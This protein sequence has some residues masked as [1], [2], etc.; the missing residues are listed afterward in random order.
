[1]E[2]E[3][4]ED[5]ATARFLNDNFVS[6]KVD[7]EERP[8]IDEVYMKA[9]TSFTGQGGW[10]L[11]VFLTPDLKPFYG[12][13]YFPP[14]PRYGMPS[15]RQLLEF[16][17]NLW[18]EKRNEVEHDAEEINKLVR[19]SYKVE[20]RGSLNPGLLDGGY[21]T[22]VSRFDAEYG[23]YGTAPKFPMP[24]YLSFLM[25]YFKR[26]GKELAIRSAT[27]TLDSMRAGGI[28]DHLAG[29]F[30][31]YSTD[32]HWLVPHFEKM[33]YD[34]ALLA[35]VFCELYQ[36]TRE[37]VFSETARTTLE[38][39]LTEMVGP[40]GGF[41]SA[42][43]ADTPDGEG[44]YYTWTKD[45][46]LSLLGAREGELFCYV[47]GVSEDGNF[48]GGRSILHLANSIEA[49]AARFGRGREDVSISLARDRARLLEERS[50]RRRPA[51]DDKILTSWNG[52][53][54]SAFAY[55]YQ[56]LQEE[57]FLTAAEKAADF[58]LTRLM[59]K[60]GR[61][62][63]RYRE[64][65]VAVPA[66]LEDYS[67]LVLGL[68][69]LY[70]ADLRSRWLEH[71]VK[72]AERMI[73]LFWDRE[74]GGGF[75]LSLPSGDLQVRVKEGYDGPIPSG[76]SAAALAL[77]K[78]AELTGK[79]GFRTTAEK[80]LQIFSDSMDAEAS[81]HTAMLSAL[82]FLYGPPKE[83]VVA[84]KKKIDAL[85]MLK[86]IQTRFMPDKVLCLVSEDDP[87]S[88]YSSPLTEGKSALEEGRPT[89]FICE[90]FSCKRPITDIAALRGALG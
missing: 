44:F 59:M 8:E 58:L 45:E 23:G 26:T 32:R 78:L 74:E 40:E 86:E 64:G 35:R 34:N 71:A 16:I 4:F 53:A 18:K 68:I 90:N 57:R 27:K 42:Q 30:H 24:N 11:S 22:L 43:D 5:E 69:D 88:A 52:L 17:V 61:L 83:I 80:T 67:L 60:D 37:G 79:E 46:I 12:G 2:H 54:I 3:S 19:D 51:I 63:R 25:R 56:A 72:L 62:F 1:M 21:A 29:G 82:S 77:L 70:E 36:I 9:V 81:A 76:N 89:V 48:E 85:P 10:P 28:H 49:A 13:T 47:Y 39:M 84:V 15:F 6:I 31:R 7:R 65:D 73:E 41:Y 55:A 75:I 14:V 87:A 33:L 50:K 20:S 38:W 66:T